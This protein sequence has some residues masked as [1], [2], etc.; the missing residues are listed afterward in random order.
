MKKYHKIISTVFFLAVIGFSIWCGIGINSCSFYLEDWLANHDKRTVATVPKTSENLPTVPILPSVNIETYTLHIELSENELDEPVSWTEGTSDTKVEMESDSEL[1]VQSGIVGHFSLSNSWEGHYLYNLDVENTD[2]SA[3]SWWEVTY[4]VPAGSKVVDYWCCNCVIENNVLVIT[5]EDY[6]KDIPAKGKVTGIGFTISTTTVPN[7]TTTEAGCVST[8]EIT[9]TETTT[10]AEPTTEALPPVQESGTPLSNHGKLS[11]NGVQLVDK[12]GSAYQ[13]KG[14]ST[15]G[16][17]WFPQYVNKEAFKTLR[18][19]WG[20]NTIRLSMYTAEYNGYCSGGSQEDLK[21]LV[22]NGVGYA[23]EL[24]MYAI[25]DWH[26]LSDNDPNMYKAQALAFFEEMA[27]KYCNYD[28][29][30]YEICNEPNGGVDWNTIK[31]YADD[32]ISVIR[33]YDND[34]IILVGTPTWSQ[35]VDVV[36][37]NPVSNGY[38]V[39]YTLHFYAATHK[40]N[41]QNK[42]V[43]ALNA[44]TPVFVSEFSICDASGNGGIDY[45]SA[46]KW[47]SLIKQYNLSYAGWSL[48]NKA[49]TSALINS[50]CAKVSG[51]SVEDLSGTGRWLREMIGGL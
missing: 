32:V 4:E 50:G 39:M 24:G 1:V 16:I 48:S 11:L 38:N 15:H 29:V 19:D 14:V 22:H 43:T 17:N 42:L 13:L 18:D 34:A 37:S 31:G 10:K 7:E 44:G 8:P 41:I 36:A 30:I 3:A 26:I 25:I 23:T 49:E 28:N 45:A 2:D 35:D 47:K 20:A 46:D 12:N 27:V 21:Q 5:P 33:K 9:E 6:N 40:D 51:W